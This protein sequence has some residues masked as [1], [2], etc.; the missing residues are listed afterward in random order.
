MSNQG[1]S[2]AAMEVVNFLE[3]LELIREGQI[4]P[5]LYDSTTATWVKA[6]LVPRP[7]APLTTLAHGAVAVSNVAITSFPDQA[8]NTVL[9][10]AS[11][12]NTGIIYIGGAAV[13]NLTGYE[14]EPS[15]SITLNI[16]NVNL[17]SAVSEVLNEK[18]R[19]MVIA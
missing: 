3:R 4:K 13:S 1:S 6:P 19:W 2:V 11:R 15:E 14:L 8:C 18:V 7:S 16:S 9:L 5:Y 10:K 12:D 17:L